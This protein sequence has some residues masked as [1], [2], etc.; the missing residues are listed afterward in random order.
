MVDVLLTLLT[1]FAAVAAT[2]VGWTLVVRSA[3]A[4]RVVGWALATDRYFVIAATGTAMLL[5]ALI[6]T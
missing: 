2:A 5:V 6:L 1:I 4:V 3:R